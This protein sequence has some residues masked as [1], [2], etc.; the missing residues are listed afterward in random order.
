MHKGFSTRLTLWFAIM[1]ALS[2]FAT[3]NAEN[4]KRIFFLHSYDI[5]DVCGMPQYEGAI[6]Q[7]SG[8]GHVAGKN[9]IIENYYMDTKRTNHTARKRETICGQALSRIGAFRPDII[10]TFDDNA[11]D[12]VLET[13]AD[14]KV[15]IVFSG[16]NGQ[17]EDYNRRK[18]FMHNRKLPGKNIT[19]VYEKLHVATALKVHS[20]LF[21]ASRKIVFLIDNSP[22][23]SAI[24]R[25]VELELEN[26]TGLESK[27]EI[28][29]VESWEHYQELV[30]WCNRQE[31]VGAIYPAALILKDKNG[32]ARRIPEIFQWTI[33]TS[34][35][36]E[37][38]LNFEFTR[39]G[40]FGGAAVDFFAMGKQA[41]DK[42]VSI[43][44][45]K[46][47]GEIAICDAKRYALGFNLKRAKT[48]DIII[49]HEIIIAADEVFN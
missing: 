3:A 1:I 7:I 25:Q 42:I 45:G 48:L 36:P 18:S 14:S 43:L 39:L 4:Q 9:L 32:E 27:W 24:A 17:P 37:I 30:H 19:G 5:E 44:A 16:L 6:Y 8:S 35:R 28:I 33:E 15:S 29:R 22:I 21:P 10:A 38:A 34:T 26:A 47:A 46:K 41:G 13:Y 20:R 2:P 40:L 23:G 31:E 49:P 11:F 12:C